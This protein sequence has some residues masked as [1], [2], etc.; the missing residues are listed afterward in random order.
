MFG[1]D[2]IASSFMDT[3]TSAVMSPLESAKGFLTALSEGDIF[4]A[5]KLITPFVPGMQPFAAIAGMLEGGKLDLGAVASAF[6]VD[7]SALSGLGNG[8]DAASIMDM[9]KNQGC[10]GTVAPN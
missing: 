4:Q 5:A 7:A 9:L 1:L 3:V 8:I 6:G 2:K 10:F